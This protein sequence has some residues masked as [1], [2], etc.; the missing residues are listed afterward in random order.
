MVDWV[1]EGKISELT[2]SPGKVSRE[3]PDAPRGF[4]CHFQS[5][6][7]DQDVSLLDGQVADQTTCAPCPNQR[8]ISTSHPPTLRPIGRIY[9]FPLHTFSPAVR[10]STTHHPLSLITIQPPLSNPLCI[11]LNNPDLPPPSFVRS[12]LTSSSLADDPQSPTHTATPPTSPTHH[13]LTM[14]S[15]SAVWPRCRLC[16]RIRGR[17]RSCRGV[18]LGRHPIPRGPVI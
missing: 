8:R 17:W 3:T 4:R 11:A 6:P 15:P 2:S 13:R 10:S 18:V 1:V 5:F 7:H 9:L 12:R 14:T 16:Q